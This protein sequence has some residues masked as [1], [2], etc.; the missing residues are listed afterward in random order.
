M[1][2]PIKPRGRKNFPDEL[3]QFGYHIVYSEGTKTEPLYV[4]SI[5]KAIANKYRCNP[6]DIEIIAASK[7]SYNTI[8]LVNYAINDIAKRLR[9]GSSIDHVWIMFDKDSFPEGDFNAA[10]NLI[11]SKNNS[12]NINSDGFNYDKETGICWHSCWSNEAFELW[13]CQYFNYYSIPHSRKDYISYL[14]SIKQ[15][16]NSGVIYKKNM[17]DIHQIFEKCGGSIDKAIKNA[18]KLCKINGFNNPSIGMYLFAEYFN[19]YMKQ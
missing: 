8:G 15:L 18:K 9:A 19:P 4:D 10:N 11:N 16:K 1:M 5:K 7:K 17:K 6:N 14:Q 13:L 3:R 2:E 12:S